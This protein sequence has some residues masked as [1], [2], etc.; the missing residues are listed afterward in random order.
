MHAASCKT[1]IYF[2]FLFLQKIYKWR[3]LSDWY[4]ICMVRIVSNLDVRD[5]SGRVRVNEPVAR[6]PGLNK[7][8]EPT[9]QQ[10][11]TETN[12]KLSFHRIDITAT[13]PKLCQYFMHVSIIDTPT[14]YLSPKSFKS[15]FQH[16]QQMCEHIQPEV[17]S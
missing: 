17:S 7:R 4:I 5:D 16:L 11:M 8:S 3:K 13:E 12:D 10:I 9:A 1:N 15:P 2:T 6:K 14:L